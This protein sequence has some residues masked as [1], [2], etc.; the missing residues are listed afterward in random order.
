GIGRPPLEMRLDRPLNLSREARHQDESG[1]PAGLIEL[2][3]RHDDLI[4]L[5]TLADAEVVVEFPMGGIWKRQTGCERFVLLRR[6]LQGRRYALVR[7]RSPGRRRA[8]RRNRARATK[9][10]AS[11]PPLLPYLEVDEVGRKLGLEGAGIMAY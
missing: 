3:R 5:D 6:P 8:R 2:V 4:V 9:H 7:E 11:M 1:T 10:D